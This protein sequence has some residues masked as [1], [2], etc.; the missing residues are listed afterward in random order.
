[1]NN[2]G[3]GGGGGGG[4]SESYHLVPVVR[5]VVLDTWS[6]YQTTLVH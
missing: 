6:R 2:G 1:M 5:T 4:G 3:R